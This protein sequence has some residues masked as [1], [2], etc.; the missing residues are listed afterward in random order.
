MFLV[1]FTTLLQKHIQ[2]TPRAA[3]IDACFSE[4][5]IF[6]ASDLNYY[7]F[8]FLFPA[9]TRTSALTQEHHP[10]LDILKGF[11]KSLVSKQLPL[12]Q[13]YNCPSE[14]LPLTQFSAQLP[15][16]PFLSKFTPAR[17]DQFTTSI[18]TAPLNGKIFWESAFVFLVLPPRALSLC[19]FCEFDLGLLLC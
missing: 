17:L 19:N 3:N 9:P 14:T 6:G 2:S 8:L 13:I 1:E 11:I 4:L 7:E 5:N 18:L 16:L 10:N 15:T 12:R